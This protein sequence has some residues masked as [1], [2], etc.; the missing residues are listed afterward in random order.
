MK[1]SSDKDINNLWQSFQT[2]NSDSFTAI[3][4]F[5]IYQLIAYGSKLC[6]DQHTVRDSIQEIFIDLFLKPKKQKTEIK[7]LKAYLFIAL[8][9]RIYKRLQ[10]NSRIE[11][12]DT[13]TE[14][15]EL[16]FHIEYS[17]QEK[18][19]Q[20]EISEEIK[21]LLQQATAK[22]P[23]KQKEIIYL[24]FEEE[25]SYEEIAAIMRISVESTRKLFYRAMLSLRSYI[26]KKEFKTIFFIL[27]R[28]KNS[29]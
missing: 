14:N 8:R 7:N 24:K 16:D 23:S 18:L 1:R 27:F 21:N 10:R 2:G 4:N 5:Y 12:L 3:Y 13:S 29:I 28:K 19:E 22:L 26:D 15:V 9:N 6:P 17:Y 11:T 20:E 25:M